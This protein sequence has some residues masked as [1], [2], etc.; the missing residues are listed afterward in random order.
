MNSRIPTYYEIHP[1]SM[2]D[3]KIVASF[4][5]RMKKYGLERIRI[6]LDRSFYSTMNISLMLEARLGFYIPVS[7]TVGWQGE[8]IDKYRDEVEMP[9]HVIHISEDE[10]KALYGM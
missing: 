2:T 3:T 7:T 6:L 4:I 8:L 10:R 9:E 1:G 5:M